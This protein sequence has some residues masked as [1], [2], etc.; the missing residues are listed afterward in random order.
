VT[1]FKQVMTILA[2]DAAAAWLWA[3]PN[4]MVVDANVHGL[5]QNAIGEALDVSRLSVG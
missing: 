2:D 4:L 3:F 1:D 5:P